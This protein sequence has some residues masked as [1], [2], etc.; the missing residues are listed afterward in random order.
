MVMAALRI[1]DFL[2][3]RTV[4]ARAVGAMVTRIAE[5]CWY[6]S[7]LIACGDIIYQRDLMSV[8]STG[9]EDLQR[10]WQVLIWCQ[11][12]AVVMRHCVVVLTF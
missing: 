3:A 11:Y 2:V 7:R 5:G 10:W 8:M 9:K 4:E 6:R 12:V 1:S